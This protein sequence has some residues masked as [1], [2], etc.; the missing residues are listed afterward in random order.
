MI[1]SG[2]S[3]WKK[4]ILTHSW[5]RKNSNVFI[6]VCNFRRSCAAARRKSFQW[7]SCDVKESFPR[8]SRYLLGDILTERLGYIKLYARWVPK[9]LTPEYRVKIAFWLYA[10][11]LNIIKGRVKHFST[12]LSSTLTEDETWIYY[13]TFGSKI[14]SLQ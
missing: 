12:Q 2:L 9:I 11:S 10:N 14:Q 5:R 8:N 13:Y 4:A 3:F 7:S 6:H 1:P